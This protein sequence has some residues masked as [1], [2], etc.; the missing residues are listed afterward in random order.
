MTCLTCGSPAAVRP[1]GH[2]GFIKA[3][4]PEILAAP[5]QRFRRLCV[6]WKRCG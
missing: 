6:R 3:A 4:D 1:E 2:E 5:P